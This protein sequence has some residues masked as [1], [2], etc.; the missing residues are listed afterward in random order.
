MPSNLTEWDARHLATA[1]D[2]WPEPASIV[3]ELLPILPLGPALDLACGAGRHSLL[4][5]RRPQRVTAIDGS[6]VALRILEERA[7][8]MQLPVRRAEQIE[9]LSDPAEPGIS[10]VQAD[11]EDVTLPASAFEL[12]LCF[13]YLQRSL[14]PQIEQALAPG[15]M[16]LFETFTKAQLEFS[17]GPH[18]PAFL[19]ES[20]ELRNA[21]PALDVLFYRELR[22][23]QGIA[24][25]AA[26]KPRREGRQN[27]IVQS[28]TSLQ[29]VVCN[30]LRGFV[31]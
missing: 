1:Q 29:T 26:Q 15:G 24:S 27:A 19:L 8:S 22:A 5:A 3:Q 28:S 18:N 30:P 14:F 12:I 13:Q 17:G 10:L 31:F 2:P 11:L 21:Y 9:N 4:L 6:S 7:F 20:G 25:L 16:L 23:G